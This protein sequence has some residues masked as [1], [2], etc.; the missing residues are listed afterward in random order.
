MQKAIKHLEEGA[1]QSDKF[2]ESAE[3]S[4]LEYRKEMEGQQAHARLYREKAAEL[5]A[6]AKSLE[7]SLGKS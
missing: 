3:K 6:A 2:A 4:A 5:R 1:A 7:Q